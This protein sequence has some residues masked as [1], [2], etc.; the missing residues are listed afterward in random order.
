MMLR[1]RSPKARAIARACRTTTDKSVWAAGLALMLALL[2]ALPVWADD[3]AATD[4]NAATD[5]KIIDTYGYSF[6]GDLSY[7]E[8]YKHFSYVNPD[9][10]KGGEISLGVVGTF[11]SMNPYTRKGRAG[12]LSSMM[13][14]SLLGEGPTG[15]AVPADVYAESYG[16]L[17]ESLEYDEGKNWV[18]F[19]MRPEAKF[20][21]GTPVTAYDIEFS[22]NLLLD[23]GLKSYADGVRKRIPKVEVIDD[24]TIKFYFAPGI[25]RR[26]LI[27]Q[28]GAVP[29]WSKAWYEKTGAGLNEGRMDVSPGS[30][31]Y[32]IDSVDVN[33][34]IVYK[35]NPD[36]WGND[37]PFN[38]GRNNFDQIRI[39]YFGD[40]T[41]SFEAFKAGVYTFR[42]ESDSK[43]WATGYD[44]PKVES[45]AI[46][47][48]DLPDGS[49]PTPTGI[50]FNLG[51]EPLKDRR[52]R[53]AL[54]LAFNFEWTNE[55]LQ[56]GLFE[57]RAS[58]TQ[59]T[60]VMAN[61]VPEGAELELLK[62]LG[63]LVPPE[64]L[65]EPALV[66]HT[67]SPE[68][69]LDRRN[70]RAAM[71]LLD[72]AGWAVGSDGIRRNAKGEA[73]KLNFLFN[74]S[75][76]GTLSGVMEN[77]V[78]NVKKLGVDITLEKVDPSQYTNRERDRDYD[79]VYDQYLTF[80]IA[81]TGLDQAYGSESSAF[82]LFNPAGLSSPLVDAII[83]AGLNAPDSANEKTALMALDRALRYEFFMIPVW[84]N[85]SHWVAYY[86]QYEHPDVIPPFELGYMDFWW[87]NQDK[88]D[89]LR[90]SGALR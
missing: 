74:S 68:R 32:V 75:A 6:Y 40:D 16:L 47:V 27:D 10:P 78:S 44:F 9:A 73:L 1:H 60:D 64:M 55:S 48:E 52:V 81:H 22:H 86:D 34:R 67:S 45:G 89:A 12:A 54:A 84:Y 41:A 66:P 42:R 51:S 2:L 35:R 90:A 82:S 76:S 25:S 61:G 13:Y 83:D 33:R 69:L 7:P 3:A 18:I 11:D 8:D 39:E 31:P 46:K 37:L 5:E 77:Y 53:Q 19:H 30:G 28:V 70:T 23:E 88:A 56:Y 62:S 72:D 43:K 17:A 80:L 65:T 4:A 57:Q 26:T 50:V 14:E 79:L 49:P 71:K 85:P 58:Y 36:Y 20:S 15:A 59:D 87:Y 29:A 63:D 21:D 38:V 24:H